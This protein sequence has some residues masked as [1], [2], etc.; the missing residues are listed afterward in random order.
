MPGGVFVIGTDTGVGKTLIASALVLGFRRL[1][2]DVGVMKPVE[3]GCKTVAGGLIG[4]DGA[5]LRSAATHELAR[6][7]KDQPDISAYR[8]TLPAAPYIAARSE[9]ID[10]EP[11]KIH[12]L[13]QEIQKRHNITVVEGIGGLLV[14]LKRDYMLSDLII[15]LN[16]PV[17][18]VAANSLGAINHTLLTYEAARSRGIHVS[19]VIFNSPCAQEICDMPEGGT[20]GY[21]EDILP[22]LGTVPFLRAADSLEA[23]GL[24]L[25]HIN[26]SGM[27]K[28]FLLHSGDPS[29]DNPG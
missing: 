29:F 9:D 22:C 4:E 11:E 14:P 18:I 1:G 23:A 12:A 13:Y 17:L 8:F 3:T 21:L 10:I 2:Y 15:K 16:I 6:P 25:E 20:V 19:G 24:A 27:L 26:L 28:D 5:M 7:Q